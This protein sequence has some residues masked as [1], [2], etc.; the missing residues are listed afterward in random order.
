[1]LISPYNQNPHGRAIAQ[2]GRP[3]D[4]S[5]A[6]YKAPGSLPGAHETLIPFI[7]TCQL[8]FFVGLPTGRKAKGKG[9]SYINNPDERR[10]GE[11]CGKNA[12]S[13]AYNPIIALNTF[14]ILTFFVQEEC[15]PILAIV[16]GR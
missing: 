3:T 8:L 13:P 6:D 10:G 9:G 7:T 12:D 4:R 5:E 1:M 15:H 11:C 2:C 14:S 16:N